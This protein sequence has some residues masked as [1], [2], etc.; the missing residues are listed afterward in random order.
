[1]AA[2]SQHQGGI[3]SP[4]FALESSK[5]AKGASSTRVIPSLSAIAIICS[6]VLPLPDASRTGAGSPFEYPIADASFFFFIKLPHL[7]SVKAHRRTRRGNRQD[8][9]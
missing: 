8:V 1:L 9:L 6:A 2:A 5:A 4:G 7:L 3:K